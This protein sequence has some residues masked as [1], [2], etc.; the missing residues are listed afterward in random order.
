M[1]TVCLDGVDDCV[2]CAG[3]AGW[4]VFIVLTCVP[5]ETLFEDDPREGTATYPEPP[6]SSLSPKLTRK[7]SFSVELGADNTTRHKTS[8]MKVL[9]KVEPIRPYNFDF[10]TLLFFNKWSEY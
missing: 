5:V 8:K 9:D 10:C 3:C 4:F 1:K 6:A 2:G 7:P